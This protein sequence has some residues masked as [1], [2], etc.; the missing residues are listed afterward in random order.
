MV[1]RGRGAAWCGGGG[2]LRGGGLRGVEGEGGCVV[3]EGG[4]MV[5]RGRGAAWCVEGEGGCVVW[6]GRGAAW[7]GGGGGLRGV[8]GRARGFAVWRAGLP[9]APHVPPV[10]NVNTCTACAPRAHVCRNAVVGK[11]LTLTVPP[12]LYSSTA[13]TDWCTCVQ[14]CCR[15]QMLHTDCTACT[16]QQYWY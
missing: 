6:R 1:W 3:V 9:P 11:C 15:G 13:G 12:V 8:E 4:C 10:L 16:V 7:C 2:G 5:W 14:G